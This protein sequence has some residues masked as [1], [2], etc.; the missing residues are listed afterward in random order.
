M[1]D[2]TYLLSRMATALRARTLLAGVLMAVAV[3]LV[4]AVL[5]MKFNYSPVPGILLAIVVFGAMT[6][7]RKPWSID[8]VQI[9]RHLDKTEPQLEESTGLLL[10]SPADLNFLQQYQVKK[11]ASRLEAL[12]L[13][14]DF[15]QSLLASTKVF[16]AALLLSLLCWFL[17]LS[18]PVAKPASVISNVP[19]SGS[20]AVLPSIRTFSLT[21][22]PPQY[23]GR[24]SR[25]QAA[26]N[27]KIEQEAEVKWNLQIEPGAEKVSLLLN[28]SLELP[29]KKEEN[30]WQ[31][32][33]K[34]MRP[35]FYQVKIDDRISEPYTME[36]I[37]DLPAVIRVLKPEAYTRIS[38]GSPARVGPEILLTDDYG[39]RA[40]SLHATVASGSGEGVKF[41]ELDL[42]F[43]SFRP[44]GNNYK[45]R[46][47]VDLK[48]LGMQPGDEL[49]LYVTATD[50]RSQ[51][52][53]SDVFI[54]SLPDTTDLLSL[55][56][57]TTGV[58]LVPEYFR[59]QRQII[60]ETE[61][62]IKGKDTMS[63]AAFQAKSND[64]GV[65]QKLLRLR[66]GKFLGEETDEE[67]PGAGNGHEDHDDHEGHE[68]E[69][70]AF[71]DGKALMDAFT[72]KHDNAED[73]TFFEPKLKAQLK[74]TLAEMWSAELQLRVYKP[75]LALP[76]EYKALLLLK[77]LQQKSRVYV[78]KTSVKT[79][80]LN[81][82]KRLSGDLD[83]VIEPTRKNEA[84]KV[85]AEGAELR[86]SLAV[87][88]II[89]QRLPL[90]AEER[91]DLN[92]ALK[93][94]FS[95]ASVNPGRYLE[96]AAALRRVISMLDQ[97]QLIVASD[98]DS[99]AR[100]LSELAGNA[101][102]LPQPSDGRRS[103]LS[104][105]YFKNLK[106]AG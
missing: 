81:P 23:T 31:L 42:A 69:K 91:A 97:P 89:R 39:I 35:G 60:I 84:L 61:A 55:E 100:T 92:A 15:N 1:A 25:T 21:I 11:I 41:K 44:G 46:Q 87:I 51:Q 9:A 27:L 65:D 48:K 95:K 43:S 30:N 58:N 47:E 53:R 12:A 24:A 16:G 66:Y 71:G 85:K 38:F 6:Y 98:L 4:A 79:T 106:R 93:E 63:K 36:M 80:P 22:V 102:K 18:F 50:S 101:E 28:D 104:S 75:E 105:G 94:M 78:A 29:L 77:D 67:I 54:V 33:R 2:K 56:G 64:L 82:E 7:L 8:A 40:A 90:E 52:S 19:A 45:L 103:T 96:G 88:S 74:A 20:A 5:L 62:L 73:A 49:Y 70:P 32:T 17:P 99:A 10:R 72:H 37:S 13:P 68:E 59:S 83:K 57:M 3:G 76:F 34:F 14:K 26:F 86:K